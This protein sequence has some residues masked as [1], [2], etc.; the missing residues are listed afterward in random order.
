MFSFPRPG[1]IETGQEGYAYIFDA[2]SGESYVFLRNLGE[3]GQSTVQLV[4][5]IYTRERVA[6]KVSKRTL[7][8]PLPQAGQ[9]AKLPEDREIRVLNHLNALVLNP[10]RHVTLTPRW[11]TCISHEDVP[12]TAGSGGTKSHANNNPNTK[13][14]CARVR[15]SYWKLCNGGSLAD[16]AAAQWPWDDDADDDDDN[17]NNNNTN[18]LSRSKSS[19]VSL[20][21]LPLLSHA[22]RPPLARPRP[23]GGGGGGGGGGE[24]HHHHPFFPV[25]LVARCIAQVCETLH[26]MY[27]AGPE[28]VFHCDLHLGNV[29]VH[30]GDDNDNDDDGRPDFYV[31][32]FG[33]ARTASEARADT[34]VL[35]GG[36]G[37]G[38][39]ASSPGGYY[40]LTSEGGGVGGGLTPT[41]A[42]PPPGTARPGQRRRWDIDRFGHAIDVLVRIAIP[43][44]MPKDPDQPPPPSELARG[45]EALVETLNDLDDQDRALAQ[46]NPRSAPPSLVRAIRKAKK[47]EHAAWMAERNTEAYRRFIEAGRRRTRQLMREGSPFVHTSGPDVPAEVRRSRAENYGRMNIAGP[48]CLIESI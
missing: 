33:W 28:P 43:P 3:G 18:P 1:C 13:V 2:R 20:L 40:Y 34:E 9:A 12:V 21:P 26:F 48:W 44:R 27:A 29:F 4:A 15:V 39:V 23:R 24:E 41:T 38:G 42:S 46:R 45:L 19:S 14:P 8:L 32:D 5:N 36:G 37:G 16:W 17:N 30:F 22:P 11:A 47:L 35:Y 6:R 31:G 7:P 25:S 10:F